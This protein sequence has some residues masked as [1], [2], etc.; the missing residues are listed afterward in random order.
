[1]NEP[2]I[3][4]GIIGESEIHFT[5]LN[6]YK[7]GDSLFSG[8][9]IATWQ[10]GKIRWQDKLYDE[11]IFEPVNESEDAFELTDVTIGIDFHWER[12]EDQLFLGKLKIV[13]EDN[14][15]IGINIIKL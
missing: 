5:F 4:V 9:H 6:P 3:H 12:K 2:Y 11:L 15:L 8:K 1:M 7:I 10:A 13:P 14:K